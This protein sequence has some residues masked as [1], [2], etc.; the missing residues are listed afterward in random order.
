MGR[1]PSS[2]FTSPNAGIRKLT[3]SELTRVTGARPQVPTGELDLGVL[4]LAWG[5]G[6]VFGIIGNQSFGVSNGKLY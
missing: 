4:Y 5:P 1:L 6:G 2:R 3:E